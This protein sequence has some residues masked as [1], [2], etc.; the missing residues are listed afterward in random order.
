MRLRR[1][2]YPHPVLGN[3]D[4]VPA[5]HFQ[6]AFDVTSD[7]TGFG[8]STRV[9]CSSKTVTRL[10]AKGSAK[11]VLHVEC[12]NT[13]FRQVFEFTGPQHRALIPAGAL[14][15]VVELNAFVRAAKD[16]PSYRI[17]GSHKDYGSA[18]FPVRRGDIL[19]VGDGIT[20]FAENEQDALRLI[21]SIMQIEKSKDSSDHPMRVDYNGPK[22][23]VF[24]FEKDF[25][26]YAK[27]RA[28]P[29]TRGQLIGT[30][31]LPVLLDALHQIRSSTGAYQDLRW[32]EKLTHRLESLGLG[33]SADPLQAAQLVLE[34]PVRRNFLSADGLCQAAVEKE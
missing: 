14:N 16:I 15:D 9:E 33:T 26:L 17:V 1:K 28:I 31:V 8:I 5:A 29:Q 6:A 24:L 25:A 7:T 13:M 11:H 12:S 4:D 2:S 20:F 19:A 30:V 34:M 18:T 3:G 10:V 22:I 21:G 27:L 32:F 23:R